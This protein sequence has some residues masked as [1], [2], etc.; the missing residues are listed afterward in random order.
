M[1]L[2]KQK[3]QELIEHLA[4]VDHEIEDLFLQEAEIPIDTIK[5]SIRK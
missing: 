3:R 1:D 4:E 2:C 5:K